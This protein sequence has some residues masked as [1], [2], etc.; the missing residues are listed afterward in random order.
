MPLR[1]RAPRV[2]LVGGV[3]PVTGSGGITVS[4]ATLSGSGFVVAPGAVVGSGGVTVSAPTVAAFG[5]CAAPVVAGARGK[6]RPG[7]GRVRPR[8]SGRVRPRDSGRR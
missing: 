2:A 7:G 1:P 6:G 8:D 5:T 4:A 3:A